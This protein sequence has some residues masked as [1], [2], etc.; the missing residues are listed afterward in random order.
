MEIAPAN[1]CVLVESTISVPLGKLLQLAGAARQAAQQNSNH[2]SVAG[3]IAN[4]RSYF[5]Q[6]VNE[7]EIRYLCLRETVADYHYHVQVEGGRIL[8]KLHGT[9]C[10]KVTGFRS[11]EYAAD[12]T[13]WNADCGGARSRAYSSAN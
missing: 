10:E 12:P 4:G 1:H 13:L 9:A 8:R 3:I 7:S 11:E 6:Q 5:T 2:A